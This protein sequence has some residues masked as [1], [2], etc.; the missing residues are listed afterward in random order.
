MACLNRIERFLVADVPSLNFY[1]NTTN[2]S[3]EGTEGM[4]GSSGSLAINSVPRLSLNGVCRDREYYKAD[5]KLN[6]ITF[7]YEAKG[8]NC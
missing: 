2:R 4:H 8:L 5:M 6:Y 1:G 7:T 3:E